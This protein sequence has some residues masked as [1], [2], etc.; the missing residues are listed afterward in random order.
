MLSATQNLHLGQAYSILYMKLKLIGKTFDEFLQKTGAYAGGGC[1]GCTCT[2]PPG[3][4]VPLRNFQKRKESSAQICQQ[5]K[6]VHVPLRYDKYKL[7][8]SEKKKKRVKGKG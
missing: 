7:K 1:T 2:P 8:K 4:K 3:K 5:N 6:N